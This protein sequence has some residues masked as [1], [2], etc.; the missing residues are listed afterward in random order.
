MNG[1]L[2]VGEPHP[3]AQSALAFIR[4]CPGLPHWQEAF[5]SCALEGNRIGEICGET[6]R[7]VLAGEPVSDRYI[8]GLAWSIAASQDAFLR[9]PNDT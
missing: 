6:L 3:A 9:L 5:S 7:R 1:D 8:L 2:S 4:E